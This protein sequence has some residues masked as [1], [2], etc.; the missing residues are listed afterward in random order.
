M[1]TSLVTTLLYPSLLASIVTNLNYTIV[2]D[3]HGIP[4]LI[5][6][7]ELKFTQ[8]DLEEIDE[9]V[10]NPPS[11]CTLETTQKLDNS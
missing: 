10:Q 11:I 5:D 2:I 9:S 1:V 4:N 3:D 7:N 8:I 6:T